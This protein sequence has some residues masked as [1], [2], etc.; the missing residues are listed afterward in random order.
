MADR[1]EKL[2]SARDKLEKYR[3][4]KLSTSKEDNAHREEGRPDS[5]SLA[6]YFAESRG[7]ALDIP[8]SSDADI[9]SHSPDRAMAVTLSAREAS[10]SFPDHHHN[11]PS[12]FPRGAAP[13]SPGLSGLSPTEF[14]ELEQP[15]TGQEGEEE[16]GRVG[17]P[18]FQLGTPRSALSS[19]RHTQHSSFDR[20]EETRSV[21]EFESVG[22]G[23]EADGGGPAANWGHRRVEEL[24]QALARENEERRQLATDNKQLRQQLTELKRSV[25]G[26]G[27]G[28][29][30]QSSQAVALEQELKTKKNTIEL[31]VTEKSELESKTAY[32]E[33]HCQ[34]LLNE[35]QLLGTELEAVRSSCRSLAGQLEDKNKDQDESQ[36]LR[37]QV[38]ELSSQLDTT[39][40][41]S[42]ELQAKLARLMEEQR[43]D[44]SQVRELSSALEIARVQLIQLR[45]AGHSA[46]GQQEVQNLSAELQA[47]RKSLTEA[48]ASRDRLAADR[49]RLTDQ[50]R[51]YS[52]D[53]AVQAERLSEQL[54][55][56]Q[57]ENAR[58]VQRESGLV[59]QIE[60]MEKQMQKYVQGGKNVTEEEITRLKERCRSLEADLRQSRDAREKLEEMYSE[61]SSQVEEMMKR[62]AQKDAKILELQ[63]LVSSLET[64]VD[65]LKADGNGLDKNRASFLAAM[66][67]DKVAA[68]RAMQQNTQLKKDLEELQKEIIN[69][70][71]GKAALLDRLEDETR[72]VER[73]SRAVQEIHG[74]QAALSEKDIS[75]QN[76]KNQVKYLEAEVT[77]SGSVESTTSHL[78][79]DL[80]AAT[81]QIRSLNSI[82]SELRSQIE[83]LSSRTTEGS[84]R[85][86]SRSPSSN[87]TRNSSD[88]SHTPD[89]NNSMVDSTLSLS[90]DS[91]VEVKKVSA[92]SSDSFVDVRHGRQEAQPEQPQ[93]ENLP[94][95][96]HQPEQHE[97]HAEQPPPAHP[98]VSPADRSDTTPVRSADGAA[99]AAVAAGGLLSPDMVEPWRQ[100][101]T[102]FI[103]AMDK[104]ATLSSDKEQLEHLVLRLQEE[105]ETVHDYII[106][107]QHQRQQQKLRIQ[108][109][110]EQLQQLSK[111]R[112]NLQ[113]KIAALGSLVGSL[114][115]PGAENTAEASSEAEEV[116]EM[117]RTEAGGVVGGTA[118]IHQD[119]IYQLL[120]EIESDSDSIVSSMG[121]FEPWFWAK[122]GSA[123]KSKIITV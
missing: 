85:G 3:K 23:G 100:L 20:F 110:D 71:N 14:L 28:A 31:L 123:G 101:Q 93:Q 83:V 102:R 38:G 43:A 27:G 18:I 88:G 6:D 113:S 75:I 95:Q 42:T 96:P 16:Q 56:Y 68:S 10:A 99:A 115:K 91:F 40:S 105:T 74:L 45:G 63:A 51:S 116:T 47:T 34:L 35:T 39:R 21:D 59:T 67:S 24:E 82:N 22:G 66:E 108:E 36:N 98:L 84:D 121:S 41:D 26:G 106:M 79:Q 81:D 119:Q 111:D 69:L 78:E 90:S 33:Q 60:G 58:L 94:E 37:I 4:K 87:R 62:L 118:K 7:P 1:D 12:Q 17:G 46:A 107:Y 9:F 80:L 104:I 54:R 120:S 114:V 112:A 89:S 13:P 122:E 73:F 77:A 19:A 50:Y 52:K 57:E 103:S 29:A 61:R 30:E 55:R 72:K 2:K 44:R 5:Y 49:E 8:P 53:L 11:L 15:G 65:M 92:A 76:L 117:P 97:E 86:D 109:K 32:L 70:N 64:S 25:G 48:L